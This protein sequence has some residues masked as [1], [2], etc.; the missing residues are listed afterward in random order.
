MK[1]YS[2]G[3]VFSHEAVAGF[4]AK[5]T[6]LLG[7]LHHLALQMEAKQFPVKSHREWTHRSTAVSSAVRTLLDGKTPPRLTGKNKKRGEVDIDDL[8]D[9]DEEES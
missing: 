5:Y 4:N 3:S 7:S 9:F 8:A 2:P 6:A 1:G